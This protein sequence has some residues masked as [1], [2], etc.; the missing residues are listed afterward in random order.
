M[1]SLSYFLV[2]RLG[3]DNSRGYLSEPFCIPG[4]VLITYMHCF[5]WLKPYEVKRHYDLPHIKN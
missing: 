4:T 1:L 2:K 5:I 3:L